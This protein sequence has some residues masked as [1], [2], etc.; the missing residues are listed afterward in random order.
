MILLGN[1]IPNVPYQQ[2][3]CVNTHLLFPHNEYSTRIRLREVTKILGFIESYRQV[4][5][6]TTI[7]GRSDVR[8][9]VILCGDFNRSPHGAVYR[10]LLSQNYKSSIEQSLSLSSSILSSWISHRSHL[11]KLVPV[12]HMFYLNPSE[13][14]EEALENVPVP[15]WMNLVY[16]ELMEKIIK[17]YGVL[18]MREIF[19]TFDQDHSTY[20]SRNDFRLSLKQLG[21]IGEG[22]PSLTDDEIE[23]LIDSAD[24]N[25]DG[26]ID[27]KEFY[28]RFWQASNN[29]EQLYEAKQK[30]KSR[31]FNVFAKSK[32]LGSDDSQFIS[33]YIEDA[34]PLGEVIV[35]NFS[36]YPHELLHGIWPPS[37]NLSDHGIV[38]CEFKCNM[39]PKEKEEQIIIANPVALKKN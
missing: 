8:I 7:C 9:P 30:Q 5:L 32:W 13:Q 38:I 36:I 31:G 24:V 15:N 37:Y 29:E 10:Y 35:N 23:I 25:G 22:L 34:R 28:D 26:T 21:F 19:S 18:S 17:D 4:N 33:K 3:L 14:E 27:Y 16:N 20:I 1:I 12:D 2:L 11:K 6:C 39:L